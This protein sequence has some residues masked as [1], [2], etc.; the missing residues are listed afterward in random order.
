[1]GNPKAIVPTSRGDSEPNIERR[2]QL[3]KDTGKQQK[4]HEKDVK[5][6][7]CGGR[8]ARQQQSLLTWKQ[9]GCK[10]LV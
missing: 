4:K 5:E 2:A 8:D 6:V 1:M 9:F 7:T 3:S 10:V